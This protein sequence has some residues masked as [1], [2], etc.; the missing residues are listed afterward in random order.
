MDQVVVITGAG[1]EGG[2][3]QAIADLLVDDGD[4]VAL[5]D[6]DGN[7]AERTAAQLEGR[8]GKARGYRCD[9]SDREAVLQVVS[10]IESEL[11]PVWGLVNGA[12]AVGIGAAEDLEEKHW[13]R[14]FDVTVAGTLWCCQAVFPSMKARGGGRI[15]NFGSEV[16]D[17]PVPGVGL[18][19]ITSKGAIRSLTR[20]L[21]IEWGQ[22]G[23]TVNTVWPVAATAAQ[24]RWAEADPAH[25]QA[26][27]DA[28]ALHR[29]GEPRDDIAPVVQF[30]LSPAAGFV[31]GVTLP[32][33]G[34]RAMP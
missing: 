29:F 34:G 8:P 6:V 7:G 13:K 1:S 27:L 26:Q 30:L 16:S 4:H 9:V 25:A 31:T 14:G 20:G 21:A 28:T 33:N 19:Y 24:K 3:G 18:S 5:L 12:V 10:R 32:A 2:L 11:G 22:Y 15:V 17:Y 23:I